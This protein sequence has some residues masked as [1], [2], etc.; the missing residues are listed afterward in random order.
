VL[1]WQATNPTA[2]DFRKDT[3]GP[4]YTS[5]PLRDQGD[6]LYVAQVAP[7]EKGWTAFFVELTFDTG[8]RLPLKL[9]TPVRV[10]P[11]VLPFQ[12][13]KPPTAES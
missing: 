8:G 9:T 1:L 13:Q 6:G 11:D 3:I 12:D 7:P 10:V 5:Q 4:A 2:R